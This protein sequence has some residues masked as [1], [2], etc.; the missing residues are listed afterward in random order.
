MQV[1]YLETILLSLGRL[2]NLEFNPLFIVS[3]SL[4]SSLWQLFEAMNALSL[5]QI[6]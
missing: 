2:N 3:Q 1:L 5:V 4:R 6:A